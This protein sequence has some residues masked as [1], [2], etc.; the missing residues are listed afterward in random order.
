[1]H[2]PASTT[3]ICKNRKVENLWTIFNKI[4]GSAI[5]TTGALH[6]EGEKSFYKNELSHE[7]F[8]VE[9][10]G[11]SELTLNSAKTVFVNNNQETFANLS[12]NF[13]YNLVIAEISFTLQFFN[14]PPNHQPPNHQPPTHRKSSDNCDISAVTDQILMKIWM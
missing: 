1:M 4:D 14:D 7:N 13:N 9:V 3:K 6:Q 10:G 12:F 8:C 5:C 2:T 11:I